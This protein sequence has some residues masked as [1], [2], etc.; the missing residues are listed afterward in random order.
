MP[1]ASKGYFAIS[2]ETTP[3]VAITTPTK[4]YPV[5]E[6]EFDPNYEF[7]EWR[8]IRGSRTAYQTL[9]GV[10]RPSATLRGPVY[11]AGAMGSFLV[12]LF[13]SYSSALEGG[14]T[15]AYKHT[16]SDAPSVPTYTLERSD[17]RSGEGGILCERLAGCKVE[18]IELEAAVNEK[19][20]MTV[21]FQSM[22]KPVTATPVSAGSITYPNMTPL[23]F[24]GATIE[25]D[26]TA[27]SLFKNIRLNIRQVLDRQETLNGSDEAYKIFEG[28][29]ECTVSGSAVFEDLTLYNKFINRTPFKLELLLQSDTVADTAPNPDIYYSLKFTWDIVKLSRHSTPFRAGEVINVDF[30]ARVDFDESSNRA[31]LVEMVNLDNATAYNS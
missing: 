14:S 21:T 5:E 12:G 3:G 9:H 30:E 18:S 24:K 16:F 13:G 2:R 29:I 20:N 10:A 17:A 28:G 23:Y 27:S 31:V 8:E 11:P 4:F 25:I 19:V 22:K 15:I 7:I 26:D 1:Q 6:V